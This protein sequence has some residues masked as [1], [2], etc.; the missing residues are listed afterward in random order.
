MFLSV[1]NV[2]AGPSA[3]H[4]IK[5][6][7]EVGRFEVVSG[8][9]PYSISMEL[10]TD[11][12]YFVE[13]EGF[14]KLYQ[15]FKPG[16]KK[17]FKLEGFEGKTEKGEELY[18][19][20]TFSFSEDLLEKNGVKDSIKRILNPLSKYVSETF[21]HLSK[22]QL[23]KEPIHQLGEKVLIVDII[24]DMF[25]SQ[26]DFTR[27]YKELYLKVKETCKQLGVTIQEP[28]R[29]RGQYILQYFSQYWHW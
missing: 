19:V 9:V 26:N 22:P 20:L 14:A 6:K 5:F 29:G 28:N 7:V 24:L 23:P 10:M 25:E 18:K 2:I 16:V 4:H 11:G 27:P 17:C 3:T 8:R 12:A 13:S 1:V 15:A 21:F